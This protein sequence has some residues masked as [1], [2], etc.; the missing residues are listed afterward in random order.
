MSS[1]GPS[2]AETA[3]ADRRRHGRLRCAD[4]WCSLGEPLDISASG[5]RLRHRGR[6]RSDADGL[7]RVGLAM[8]SGARADLCARVVW[9]RRAGLFGGTE[10]GL[11]FVDVDD[12]TRRNLADVAA[13]LTPVVSSWGRT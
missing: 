7:L 12:A 11:V 9:T 1:S 3:T 6:L 8:P 10:S 4:L 13:L 5:M 2:N